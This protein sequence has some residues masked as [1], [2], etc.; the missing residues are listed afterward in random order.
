MHYTFRTTSFKT[1]KTLLD[2]NWLDQKTNDIDIYCNEKST[3]KCRRIWQLFIAVF[4][5]TRYRLLGKLVF[6]MFVFRFYKRASA[7]DEYFQRVID[8]AVR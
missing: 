5:N 7:R 2:K 4:Y 8:A 3:L 6:K 1:C